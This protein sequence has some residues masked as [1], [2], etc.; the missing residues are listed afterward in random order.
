MRNLSRTG[1]VL[2]VAIFMA[3][4]SSAE[5]FGQKKEKAP[6]AP[7]APKAAKGKTTAPSAYN[8]VYK[9]PAGKTLSYT[10]KTDMFM[11]MD[12]NGQTF[13]VNVNAVLSCTATGKGEEGGNLKLEIKIDSLG[14]STD[15]PQGSA[16]GLITEVSGKTFTMIL[17]PA[18]KEV[19]LK[20]AEKIKFSQEGVEVNVAQSFIDYFPDLPGKP[21]KIG[22]TWPTDDTVSS[23][24]GTTTVKQITHAENTFAGI[25]TI[26]GVECAKITSVLTGTRETSAQT[27]GTDFTQSFKFTGTADLFF[28][29]REGYYIRQTANSKMTGMMEITS[30]GM[31]MPITGDLVSVSRL[32]K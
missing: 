28:A 18:G 2:L 25:E 17:S 3:M 19:D 15:T 13:N 6:K 29:I 1:I 23:K 24:A 22:D 21:V 32:K 20:D 8:L 11:V 30:Q 4:A 5:C 27:M 7:K 16:G 9:I 31:S 12:F 10:G 26:D 14:Q